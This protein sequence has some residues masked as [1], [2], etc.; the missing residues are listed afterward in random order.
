[1]AYG[2]LIG[3][4]IDDVTWPRKVGYIENVMALGRLRVRTNIIL[5]IK[6]LLNH[7]I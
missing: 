5:F 1:M 6:K 4:V 3:H 7:S 2:E